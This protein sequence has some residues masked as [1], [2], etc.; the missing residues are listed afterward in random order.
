M[1]STLLPKP[2]TTSVLIK[3]ITFFGMACISEHKKLYFHQHQLSLKKINIKK[4]NSLRQDSFCRSDIK[5]WL[6]C[7]LG[8]SGAGDTHIHVGGPHSVIKYIFAPINTIVYPVNI[9]GINFGI[10]FCF[11]IGHVYMLPYGVVWQ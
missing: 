6:P 8:F 11:P 9:V 10:Y 3:Q 5:Y 4:I 1:Y 2:N 7:L